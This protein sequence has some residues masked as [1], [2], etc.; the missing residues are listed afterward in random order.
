MA[1]RRSGG[2]SYRRYHRRIPTPTRPRLRPA[3]GLAVIAAVMIAAAVT[4]LAVADDSGQEAPTTGVSG[5]NTA[6]GD[7]P[8]APW[9]AAPVPR[10]AVPPAWVAAWEKA[11]NRTTCALL[12]P[13]DGGPEMPRTESTGSAT[14]GDKGWDIFLNSAAGTVEVLGLF[15][16]TAPQERGAEGPS[17]TKTW[18]DGSEAKYRPDAGNLAPGSYDADRSAFEAVLTLPDQ[19]CA[20]R[21]YDTLGRVHLE[22]LFDRLRLMAP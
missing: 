14:P 12:H 17:Y 8:A 10:S 6:G 19:A 15:D 5:L 1:T 13:T 7:R 2:R 16:K 4:V 22:S 20:Y 11:G 3:L 9:R 18:A 21:I